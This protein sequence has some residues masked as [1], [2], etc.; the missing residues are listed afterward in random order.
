MKLNEGALHLDASVRPGH[1]R[2]MIT[3]EGGGGLFAIEMA[4]LDID[5]LMRVGEIARRAIMAE[6]H[7]TY[8][9]LVEQ[10]A[11]GLANEYDFALTK[12]ANLPDAKERDDRTQ[13]Y[14][15]AMAMFLTYQI[16]QMSPGKSVRHFATVAGV[17]KGNNEMHI[18]AKP[19]QSGLPP[20]LSEIVLPVDGSHRGHKH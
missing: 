19:R 15:Q 11:R 1:T 9:D 10:N 2:F 7:C 3:R 8:Q 18:M 14:A 13:E 16:G 17:I 5:A 20:L 4:H 12:Y 6:E